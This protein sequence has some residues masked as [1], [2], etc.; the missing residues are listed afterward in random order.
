MCVCV[1]VTCSPQAPIETA[2]GF[3]NLVYCPGNVV[4]DTKEGDRP[5]GPVDKA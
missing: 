2:H 1:V 4:T 3:E 5:H